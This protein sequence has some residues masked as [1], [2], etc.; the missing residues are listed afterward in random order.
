[1]DWLRSS[2]LVEGTI[3]EEDLELFQVLDDP[4]DVVNAIN[5]FYKD[6]DDKADTSES[7][8]EFNL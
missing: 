4:D 6:V 5:S 3:S 2:M 7:D 1:M 8:S